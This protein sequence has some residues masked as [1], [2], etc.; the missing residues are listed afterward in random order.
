M[1]R[2]WPDD[3]GARRGLMHANASPTIV[4]DLHLHSYWWI[5]WIFLERIL[6]E[7]N[8]TYGLDLLD[9]SR[10]IPR[11]IPRETVC[12]I[13]DHYILTNATVQS[14]FAGSSIHG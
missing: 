4:Q 5:F 14:Q 13:G 9:L 8:G 2:Q 12:E 11:M 1:A 7:P 6:T 10:M 3:E